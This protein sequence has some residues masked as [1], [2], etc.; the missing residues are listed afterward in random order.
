MREPRCSEVVRHTALDILDNV[1]G[2]VRN[3]ISTLRNLQE[4]LMAYA[5]ST[6]SNAA[7][8]QALV[9]S[10][11]LQNK[12]AQTFTFLFVVLIPPNGS[13]LSETS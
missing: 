5:R 10:P 6:Y 1:V 8:S 4:S 3:D 7:E 13:R 9:D 11:N 12:L 2:S